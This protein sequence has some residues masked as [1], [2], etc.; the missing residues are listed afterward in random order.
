MSITGDIALTPGKLLMA[1][2]AFPLKQARAIEPAHLAD[3]GKIVN[4]TGDVQSAALYKT[5]VPRRTA[6]LKANIICGSK[7][8][9]WMLAVFEKNELAVAFFAGAKEP[10]LA[11]NAVAN[12]TDLCG[13]FSYTAAN[14]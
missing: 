8:A 11:P 10:D 6:L 12:S 7:D 9:E 4:A 3:V 13:T 1:H 2:R 5:M 14:Q